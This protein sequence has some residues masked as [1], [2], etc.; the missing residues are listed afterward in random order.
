MAKGKKKKTN[1]QVMDECHERVE[2]HYKKPILKRAAEA[3]NAFVLRR[4]SFICSLDLALRGGF[5][6]G[7][8]AQIAAPAGVG[9]NALANQVISGCQ[10]VYG[11]EACVAWI[12]T[13]IKYDK[14]HARINGVIV[15]SSPFEIELENLARKRTNRS[16]LNKA[17]VESRTI[18]L[19]EFTIADEGSS[20]VKLQAAAELVR[21]NRCQVIV[22]DSLAATVS[23]QRDKTDLDDEPQQ[24]AEARLLTSFQ[25]K[26]WVAFGNPYEGGLNMTTVL[27]INQ[28]R[29]KRNRRSTFE[30][31]WQSAGAYALR[32]GKLVDIILNKGSRI[33]ATKTGKETR[34]YSK[35][36]EQL[37]KDI[38]W[39]IDKG[40]AGCHEGLSGEVAYYFNTGFNIYRDL[41]ITAMANDM[42]VIKER[43][44]KPTMHFF[45]TENGEEIGKGE[46]GVEVLAERA[47]Q[48]KDFFDHVYKTVMLANDVEYLHKL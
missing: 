47:L 33:Y 30:R 1:K 38:V 8:I 39:Q 25:Q 42:I 7:G 24:S 4:P 9:K 36:Y 15:P 5:P 31:E 11:E 6:A 19:G 18:E 10:R 16:K 2:K 32:H 37:G 41:I 23:D 35:E 17:Q 27:A 12:W 43:K 20:A 22:I 26:L 48:D 21:E 44:D 3:S 45:Y 13:E 14:Q 40:K 29:A 46:G 34:K 28:V